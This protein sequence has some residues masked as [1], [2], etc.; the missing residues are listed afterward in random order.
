MIMDSMEDITSPGFESS[1]DSESNFRKDYKFNK[2]NSNK[3]SILN[4][5]KSSKYLFENMNSQSMRKF[6]LG[7]NKVRRKPDQYFNIYVNKAENSIDEPHSG[8]VIMDENSDIYSPQFN[9]DIGRIQGNLGKFH[10]LQT[11]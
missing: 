5:L 9:K 10:K 11:F 8:S 4:K 1:Q 2:I 7:L 6:N 3:F